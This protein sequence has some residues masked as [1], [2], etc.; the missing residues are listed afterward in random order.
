M[1]FGFF[2]GSNFC[3][4]LLAEFSHK[5]FINIHQLIFKRFCCV[6]FSLHKKLCY[7]LETF[8]G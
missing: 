3:V 6:T 8:L 5:Y 2:E 1:C 4:Y 7:W